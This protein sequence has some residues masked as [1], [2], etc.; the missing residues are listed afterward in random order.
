MSEPYARH[1]GGEV[2]A[3]E[4]R[5]LEGPNLYFTR[6][7]VKVSLR[8]PGL[9]GMDDAALAGRARAL[10]LSAA[11]CGTA[12]S[13]ARQR[14]LLRLVERV[15]RRLARAGGVTRLGVRARP[16]GSA[17]EVVVAY[18]WNDRGRAAAL[19]RA[20]EDLLA[21]CL[22]ADLSEEDFRRAGE[23]V[24]A[25][26]ASERFALPRPGV[27]VVAITGT[28]GK[29]T[30]TR[31]VAHI[32][33]TAGLRTGWSST[34]GVLVQGE[35]VE[36]G[37]YSGPAGARAVLDADGVQLAVLE[38]ARGGMLFKGLG[39]PLND[40]SIVTNVSA[41]HLGVQG[42]GTLDEL[43]EVK[44]IITRVT[45]PQ[46]WVVLNGD[47][48]RVWAM[49]SAAGGRP[50]CFSLNPDSPA[51]R[52][53]LQE[54]GRGITVMDGDLVVLRPGAGVER[55]VSVLDVPITMGG[56]SGHN[57][58][59][60][61]AATAGALGLGLSTEAVVE[62]L[63]TFVPDPGHNPG[64]MNT[65][66]VPLLSGGEASVVLDMAHN[67]AGL[68][69]LLTVADGLRPPGSLVLL[70][71]GT[72]GDRTDEI[73][74]SMGEMAGLRA[75]RVHVV[76][77]EHYLRGR[78]MAELESFLR[79]GLTRV[80]VVPLS[81]SET[82]LAGLR[83][84]LATARDGDVVT[85]MCHS[86]RAQLH[87]WLVS[88]GSRVDTVTDVRRKV[89]AARGEH[90][91]EA[92][93]D[94]LWQDPD[95]GSR[96]EA[97]GRMLAGRPGDARLLFEAAGTYDSAGEEAHAVGLYDEALRAGLREPHRHR[98]LLQKAS[99]LR[100]LGR[101]EEALEVLEVAAADRPDSPAVAC[102][103]ALVLHDL[104]RDPEAS[105]EL[106]ETVV[107]HSTDA[108]VE[109]YRGALTRFVQE[110]DVPLRT[111]PATG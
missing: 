38:T 20:L 88:R 75:D 84:I 18:P 98:A 44:A 15:L 9:L 91:L 29:T 14:F 111:S 63:R 45:T 101:G 50:W 97:A 64:R 67:E 34:D 37:D 42:I 73:L 109:N 89:V 1:P 66:T 65:Y 100:H 92:A 105:R 62:G 68:D 108:D 31:L 46:G 61:L 107:R 7:A 72:G 96:I 2:E 81:S 25:V 102:F 87:D 33:M 60:A 83:T 16:G 53:A 85:M 76:H 30:T 4:V 94:R 26:P 6:P 70:G 12:G 71:L 110:W 11:A 36:S 95:A 13:E 54:H 103:R 24:R 19:A 56:L 43:A 69:A 93:I 49:R 51:L 74:V 21:C 79:E 3:T 32:G 5:L 59:N 82:E 40:V 17:D 23:A 99:S 58:A 35:L 27:P 39:V 28:N 80:G 77:K 52:E 106:L 57:T 104:G 55:L 48:P 22:G 78:T 10:N 8:L 90:E 41:D 86:H 47:D